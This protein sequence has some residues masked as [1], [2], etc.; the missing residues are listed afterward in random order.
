MKHL[1]AN[2]ALVGIGGFFGAILRYWLAVAT[3]H[4]QFV[5]HVGTLGANL[6]GGFLIGGIVQLS[7]L[8]GRL[9]PEA[10]LML[11]TGL[12]GGLTTMSSMIYETTQFL[13][14]EEADCGGLVTIENVEVIRYLHGNAGNEKKLGRERTCSRTTVFPRPC[15]DPKSCGIRGLTPG[16]RSD[17]SPSPQKSPRS[18]PPPSRRKTAWPCGTSGGRRSAQ[19][20]AWLPT[21]SGC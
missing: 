6:I 12:C 2:S 8:T 16:T 17:R 9:S 4:H 5:L 14:E 21:P 3:Q 7:D 19:S 11:T 18:S 20:A 15:N 1:I 13:R 10:R